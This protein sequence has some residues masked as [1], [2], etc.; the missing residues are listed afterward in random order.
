MTSAWIVS[1]FAIFVWWFAT[2]AILVAVR[3]ADRVGNHKAIVIK[4][5]PI[6]LFGAWAAQASLTDLTATGAY[7]GFAGALA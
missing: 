4:A 5:L 2:G 6:L 1:L 7:L 3:R